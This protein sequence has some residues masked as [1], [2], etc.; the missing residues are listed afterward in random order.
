MVVPG[1][2]APAAVCHPHLMWDEVHICLATDRI[3]ERSQTHE[4][5]SKEVTVGSGRNRIVLP[6]TCS[7]QASGLSAELHISLSEPL[8]Q[9]LFSFYT[10]YSNR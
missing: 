8:L 5:G 4:H 7:K 9:S 10:M 6:P 1:A 3:V 2:Q